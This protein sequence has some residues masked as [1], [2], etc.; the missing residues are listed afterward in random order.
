M[1][2]D[3]N[4]SVPNVIINCLFGD[5]TVLLKLMV[6]PLFGSNISEIMNRDSD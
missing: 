1:L 6:A 5:K 4:I 3:G 2:G